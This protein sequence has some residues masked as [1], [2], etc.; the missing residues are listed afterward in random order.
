M[1]FFIDLFRDHPEAVS[2]LGAFVAGSVFILI[3]SILAPQVDVSIHL[4]FFFAFLGNLAS[5]FLW[6]RLGSWVQR[7]RWMNFLRNH[8]NIQHR[9][10]RFNQKHSPQHAFY[11]VGIKFVY[12][13]RILAIVSLGVV[14]YATHRFLIYNALAVAIINF[15]I[16]YA[17]WMY[18]MGV[19]HYIEAFDYTVQI[20]TLVFFGLLGF[21]GLKKLGQKLLLDE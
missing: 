2:L 5:D 3:L 21:W 4:I 11:F 12:G 17:G 8:P 1:A 13:I 18:A 19:T 14:R 16:C 7:K 10:D 15:I 9:I 20:M 6:F